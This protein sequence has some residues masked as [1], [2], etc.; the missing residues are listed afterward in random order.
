MIT[1]I[2]EIHFEHI[3]VICIRV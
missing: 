2:K 3:W 1:K